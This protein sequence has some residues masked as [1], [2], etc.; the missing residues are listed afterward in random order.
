MEKD[1][2][3]RLLAAAGV[4]ALVQTRV[5]WV[6]RPSAQ[7]NQPPAAGLPSIRLQNISPGRDY[8]HGGGDALEQPRV[9]ID[10]FGKSA[11]ESAT[12]AKAVIAAIEP[13][14]AVGTTRFGLAM[15]DASRDFD[16]EELPGGTKVYRRSLDFIIFSQPV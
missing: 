5:A 4:A 6:D 7:P 10:C 15:L 14:A 3:A 8:T 13:P 2:R 12:L 9:Q 11:L 16:P 1:L